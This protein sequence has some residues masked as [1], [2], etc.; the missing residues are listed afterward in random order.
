MKK[1][2]K[3]RIID[4]I[5]DDGRWLDPETME[6]FEEEQ[7]EDVVD[8]EDDKNFSLIESLKKEQSP[9]IKGWVA[10]GAMPRDLDF[11]TGNKPQRMKGGYA[12]YWYPINGNVYELP[13]EIGDQFTIEFDDEPIEV[14]LQI[15]QL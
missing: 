7:L 6:Y 12:P 13:D 14:E 9:K 5:E 1:R 10:R 2:I 8:T 11:Y 4:V 15:R 3:P